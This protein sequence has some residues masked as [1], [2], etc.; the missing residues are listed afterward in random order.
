MTKTLTAIAIGHAIA[1][2]YIRSVDDPA[3]YYLAEWDDPAHRPITIRHLLNMASGLAE[4]YDF[5]PWS[6]RM[7][8]VMGTDIVGPNL[9]AEVAG[10][11]GVKF[12]HINPPPQLL[13]VIV[14]RATTR[15]F[16]DYFSCL[17]Q[18]A[19][20][21]FCGGENPRPDVGGARPHGPAP[22]G[23]ATGGGCRVGA[24]ERRLRGDRRGPEARPPPRR[25]GAA[26]HRSG[27]RAGL[28][29]GQPS[30]AARGTRS[31]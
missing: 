20:L 24:R 26:P 8:R 3:Y 4:S 18:N 21:I 1:D 27:R 14:E 22:R 31:P 16:A 15:R 9:Q 7:Q 12:A 5:S 10:P 28:G 23:G 25:D 30:R 29:E 11:P 19:D 17:A 13:G 2:G 6:L